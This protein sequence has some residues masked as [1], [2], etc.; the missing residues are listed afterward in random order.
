MKAGGE[1]RKFVTQK[2]FPRKGMDVGKQEFKGTADRTHGGT[3]ERNGLTNVGINL[4]LK[5][6]YH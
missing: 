1:S 6:V 5:F 2:H 3:D 4:I